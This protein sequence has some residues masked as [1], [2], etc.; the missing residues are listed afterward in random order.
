[1]WNSANL[2]QIKAIYI[3]WNLVLKYTINITWMNVFC[4]QVI[5]NIF[6]NIDHNPTSFLF[7]SILKHCVKSVQI[8]SLFWSVFPCIRTEYEDLLSKS[9]YSVQMRENTDQ[10]KLRVWTLFTQWNDSKNPSTK[11]CAFGKITSGFV[12]LV[13]R[14]STCFKNNVLELSNQSYL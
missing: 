10:K 5:W 2:S 9:R 3:F 8:R 4:W 12:L 11:I 6:T 1:M 7:L 13:K 14:I